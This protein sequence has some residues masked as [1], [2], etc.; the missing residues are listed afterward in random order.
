MRIATK[1][2]PSR[3]SRWLATVAFPLAVL[4]PAVT[5][6][7]L[8]PLGDDRLRRSTAPAL[9]FS[10]ATAAAERQ[11]AQDE[12]DL[13]VRPECR[14]RLLSHGRRTAKSVLML[15]GYTGCPD[16]LAALAQAFFDRGY[17]VYIARE[18]RHGRIR[19]DAHQWVTARE[20]VAYADEA[21]GIAAGLG[22]EFGVVG[23]SAGAN[24]ATWL[25][26]YR[27][28]VHRAL[29]LSPFYRPGASQAP[30]LLVKPM[31]VLWGRRVL[32]DR[33]S[34]D[35][36]YSAL[37]QYLQVAANYRDHPKNDALTGLAV[38][39]SHHDEKI[40]LDEAT[41]LPQRIAEVNQVPL[42]RFEIPEKLGIPHDVSS[43]E[44]LGPHTAS[45]HARY[46]D[47]YEGR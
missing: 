39:V 37:A 25:V 7:Y 5:T 46:L 12:S 43:P 2:L 44:G 27:N 36:Y 38:V 32:P 20:L 31:V 8:W 40:D 24:L 15:H 33:K 35:M 3:R 26:E 41:A 11:V 9:D 30:P 17:N 42:T 21:A 29:L 4:I 23:Q 47:L 34:G 13:T 16:D 22:D 19:E 14:T 18:P 1:S 6:L 45:F 28:D 10:N